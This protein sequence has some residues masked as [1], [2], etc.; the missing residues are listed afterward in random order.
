[1]AER[2]LH[3]QEVIGSSPVGPI[4]STEIKL[5]AFPGFS[6]GCHR[7]PLILKVLILRNEDFATHSSSDDGTLRSSEA[8]S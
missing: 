1:M 5:G 7:V 3:T 8:H 6:V 2:L 4:D